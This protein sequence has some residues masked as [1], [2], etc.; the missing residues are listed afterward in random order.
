MEKL[1]IRHADTVNEANEAHAAALRALRDSANEKVR[2]RIT[3]FGRSMLD[4][5]KQANDASERFS[6]ELTEVM[7]MIDAQAT[8]AFAQNV[9]A[10]GL[11]ATEMMTELEARAAFLKTGLLP[12]EPENK[13][14][15]P[16]GDPVNGNDSS[17]DSEQREAPAET[18]AAA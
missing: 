13:L 7:T 11:S 2:E 6:A 4:L 12:V 18:K 5:V 1:L 17:S 16:A 14:T 8:E 15:K 9:A 3:E 10:I